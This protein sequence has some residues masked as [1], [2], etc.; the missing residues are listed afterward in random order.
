MNEKLEP[1]L[2]GARSDDYVKLEDLDISALPSVSYANRKELPEC[3]AVYFAVSAKGEILYI[4]MTKNL[5]VRWLGHERASECL[6]ECKDIKIAWLEKPWRG[7][8]RFE[9]AAISKY[10]P[11]ANRVI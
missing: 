4:G 3:K 1:K 2:K 7:F 10:L 11:K 8:I 5:R 6:D 9:K